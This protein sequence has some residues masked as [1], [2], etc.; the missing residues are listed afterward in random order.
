MQCE[1]G[2]VARYVA[3]LVV[4]AIDECVLCSQQR[5]LKCGAANMSWLARAD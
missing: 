4:E 1:D 2:V 5:A 3:Q